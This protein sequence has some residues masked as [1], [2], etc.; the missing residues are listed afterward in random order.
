MKNV[1]RML[2]ILLTASSYSQAQI[3]H[4][5][6]LESLLSID[7]VKVL[8]SESIF[9]NSGQLKAGI[10]FQ[11]QMD[12][13]EH[14][15]IQSGLGYKA[16]STATHAFFPENTFQVIKTFP[17]FD[18]IQVP[19]GVYYVCDP[20]KTRFHIGFRGGY[21]L[22]TQV[23]H[24]LNTTFV[25]S[26]REGNVVLLGTDVTGSSPMTQQVYLGTQVDYLKLD[27]LIISLDLSHYH[28]FQSM[29][30]STIEPNLNGVRMISEHFESVGS[31]TRWGI[32]VARKIW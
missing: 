5:I 8:N 24:E 31:Y 12:I 20:A 15:H 32:T 11:Y 4:Q 2:L 19:I 21:Q 27:P 28:G 3:S 6:G 25:S 1:V 17:S 22:G 26:K 9:R 14:L 7:H 16:Y 18:V 30:T 10:G 29:M 23:L 13:T